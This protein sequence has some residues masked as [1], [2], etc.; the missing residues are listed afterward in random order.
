[1]EDIIKDSAEK[2]SENTSSNGSSQAAFE[3]RTAFLRKLN[4]FLHKKE[5]LG[6]VK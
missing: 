2:N 3:V 1:M 4:Q 5:K 6:T